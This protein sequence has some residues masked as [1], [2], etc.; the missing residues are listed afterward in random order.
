MQ[1]G[2]GV[3]DLT[4]RSRKNVAQISTDG[5][6]AQLVFAQS[7][8]TSCLDPSQTVL[9]TGEKPRSRKEL[10][11]IHLLGP[12]A[13]LAGFTRFLNPTS[14]LFDTPLIEIG[15]VMKLQTIRNLQVHGWGGGDFG[16]T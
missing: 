8:A 14:F 6:S 7:Y 15:M 13:G 16:E 10:P 1:S 3:F 9:E 5:D 11:P 12:R 4:E 2:G